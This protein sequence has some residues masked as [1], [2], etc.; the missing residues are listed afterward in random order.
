M[1]GITRCA[2]D[3]AAE[4]SY[5]FY[6]VLTSDRAGLAAHLSR[7]GIANSQA[8]RRNDH[9]SVFASSQRD[10]PGL[11]E[12]YGRM[13]HIPCGWWVDDAMRATIAEVIARGW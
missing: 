3:S 6:T 5:W 4:P 9:H 1:P 8:H 2:C 7:H 13:V 12:F 11:D 10:L